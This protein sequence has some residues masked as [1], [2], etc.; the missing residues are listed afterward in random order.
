LHGSV[1]SVPWDKTSKRLARNKVKREVAHHQDGQDLRFAY[2]AKL[3]GTKAYKFA[4]FRHKTASSDAS[5]DDVQKS[6]NF[7]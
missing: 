6:D 2:F 1:H 7:K 3:H 5:M 4:R